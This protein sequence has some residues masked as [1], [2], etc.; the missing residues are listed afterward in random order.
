MKASGLEGVKAGA[1]HWRRAR[2][3]PVAADFGRC[4]RR[5]I[6]TVNAEEGAY[7]AGAPWRQRVPVFNR[8]WRRR[9]RRRFG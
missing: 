8:T 2:S 3:P 1:Y 4:A 9:V 7:G 6:A 5:E